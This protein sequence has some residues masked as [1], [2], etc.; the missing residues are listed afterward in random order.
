MFLFPRF[1]ILTL[2][3]LLWASSGSAASISV[4][5][6]DDA[7]KPVSDAIVTVVI[8]NRALAQDADGARLA[9][10][11][12]NQENET[13]DPGVVVIRT[14]GAVTFHN[15]DHTRHHVYSFK[16]I[17]R[18]ELLQMPGESSA[19][20]VFD[21]PGVVVVGCNIHDHMT[22][23]I[24]VTDAPWAR[25]TDQGGLASVTGLPTGRVSVSVWHHRLRPNIDPPS[26]SFVLE[27]TDSA[28][29]ITI[30]LLPPRR[31]RPRDY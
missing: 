22:A 3:A 28:V 31:P 7:G 14:G 20:I 13:F 30:P 23:Y 4:T 8:E 6:T 12:I 18:F 25:I 21:K 5:I 9:S 16:P 2:V 29:A 26:H 17:R 1:A 27:H 10:A 19:P 15:S 24:L 11:T